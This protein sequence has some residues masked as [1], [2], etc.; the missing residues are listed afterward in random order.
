MPSAYHELHFFSSLSHVKFSNL[1]NNL[2]LPP[3]NNDQLAVI[4]DCHGNWFLILLAAFLHGLINLD[5]LTNNPLLQEEMKNLLGNESDKSPIDYL[6]EYFLSLYQLKIPMH[7]SYMTLQAFQTKI[8]NAEKRFREKIDYLAFHPCRFLILGDTLGD[9]GQIDSR[10]LYLIKKLKISLHLMILFSNHDVGFLLNYFAG[11]DVTPYK[12]Y[13]KPMRSLKTLEV[14]VEKGCID[15][16]EINS[17]V[18]DSFLPSLKLFHYE[19]IGNKFILF[20]HAPFPLAR[21]G[22]VSSFLG[23]F[24]DTSTVEALKQSIDKMNEKFLMLLLE[25]PFSLL[26]IDSNSGNPC[27][28]LPNHPLFLLIWATWEDYQKGEIVIDNISS[29]SIS[30]EAFLNNWGY[31]VLYIHGHTTSSPRNDAVKKICAS[32]DH[33]FGKQ[34]FSECHDLTIKKKSGQKLPLYRLGE[35]VDLEIKNSIGLLTG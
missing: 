29:G 24:F 13:V 17:Y 27:I 3:L 14:L 9:R 8:N 4:G 12:E 7:M 22:T 2:A 18:H 10:T 28:M 20:T 25:Q 5:H 16:G 35:G 1:P 21:Y 6:F 34:S 15:V 33:S 32:L 26:N 19:H 23:V 30:E 31:D 11:L